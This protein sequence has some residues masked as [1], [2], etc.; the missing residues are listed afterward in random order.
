MEKVATL[1]SRLRL[2]MDERGETYQTLAKKLGMNPQSL[3][4]YVLGRRDPKVATAAAMA[5]ALNVEPLWL[6]G[7]DIPATLNREAI[8][9]H[10]ERLVPVLGS[11]R[12]GLPA[13]AL[14]D[15]QEYAS[16]DVP[17]P[18]EHFYLR[19]D[20]D[21]MMNAG[22]R[23]GDLVLLRRQDT[24]QSGQ[25]VACIV[26]GEAATLKRFRQQGD[27]VILQPENPA[28]EPRIVPAQEFELGTAHIVGVAVKLVRDL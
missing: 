14:Q 11:I 2:L 8:P 9:L 10:D 18:E 22:I 28:Y 19:V 23:S 3:N 20:G 16:A 15:I 25:I 5:A 27:M 26:E 4:R 6:Q 21:S 24:A 7:Y 13:L 1:G 12:A 17:D